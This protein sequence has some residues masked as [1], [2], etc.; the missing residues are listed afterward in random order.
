VF[1]DGRRQ[2]NEHYLY[3][4]PGKRFENRQIVTALRFSPYWNPVRVNIWDAMQSAAEIFF[5]FAA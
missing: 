4:M 2:A 5:A 3:A 1:A